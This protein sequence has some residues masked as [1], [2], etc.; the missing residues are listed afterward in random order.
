MERQRDPRFDSPAWGVGVDLVK[1]SE[2]LEAGNYFRALPD[3]IRRHGPNEH[4]VTRNKKKRQK[5][6]D[7]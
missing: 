2:L 3:K 4:W 6:L 5:E 1:L 7:G